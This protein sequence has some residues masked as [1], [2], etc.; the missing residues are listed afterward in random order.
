MADPGTTDIPA[1]LQFLNPQ[2]RAAVMHG[3]EPLLI[4]AGAGTIT[5]KADQDITLGSL[6]TDNAT[7][8]AVVITTNNGNIVDGGDAQSAGDADAV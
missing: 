3:D 7:P 5:L 4:I 2:Q 6:Q 1:F 8:G